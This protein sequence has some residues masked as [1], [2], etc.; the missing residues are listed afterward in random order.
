MEKKLQRDIR[1]YRDDYGE[2]NIYPKTK[3][4]EKISVKLL[5]VRYIY[6]TRIVK[7]LIILRSLK[8]IMDGSMK[9][10]SGAL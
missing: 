10:P 3:T 9:E 2:K 7:T 6:Q 5:C 4:G 1:E 8:P